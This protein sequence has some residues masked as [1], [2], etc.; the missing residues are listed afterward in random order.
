MSPSRSQPRERRGSHDAGDG[1]RSRPLPR[2]G[3]HRLGLLRPVPRVGLIESPS[4][5][6]RTPRDRLLKSLPNGHWPTRRTASLR[7]L[8]TGIP[9]AALRPLASGTAPDQAAPRVFYTQ[10]ALALELRARGVLG[11]EGRERQAPR[12]CSASLRWKTTGWK[13][14]GGLCHPP[15]RDPRGCTAVGPLPRRQKN[16]CHRKRIQTAW[17]SAWRAGPAPHPPRSGPWDGR[18]RRQQKPPP[19]APGLQ[20]DLGKE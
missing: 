5:H 7:L 18:R 14:F 10:G 19:P 1:P 9:L 16:K 15:D 6:L 11:K 8:G 20:N 4:P 3:Q 13:G 2:W 17:D 12:G